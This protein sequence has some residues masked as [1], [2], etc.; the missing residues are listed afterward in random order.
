ML[1]KTFMKMNLKI[2]VKRNN[3]VERNAHCQ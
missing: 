3:F 2:K 1:I